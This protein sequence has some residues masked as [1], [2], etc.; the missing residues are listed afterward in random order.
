MPIITSNQY[1]EHNQMIDNAQY[2]MDF[3]YTAGWTKNAICG[4]LGNME[5]ESTMNSGLWESLDEGN[6]QGGFGLVQWTPVSDLVVWLDANGY[7]NDWTNIT[8]QLKRILAEVAEGGQWYT[9]PPYTLTFTEFTHSTET[10]E[11]LA[12]AFI[13]CYER[14]FNADQP[15]R[16][17]QAREWFNT[18]NPTT[19]QVNKV[20]EAILWM[21]AI[22][23]DNT[24]GY[25]QNSRC[26]PDYDCSSFVISG[27]EQAG[28]LLKTNG[29][30]YT[31]D[32][33]A[34][35]LSTGFTQVDWNNDVNN[36]VR[37]D[38]ILNELNHVCCYIGNGKI[39][40][41]SANEFGT[42]TGGQTGDQTE[43]EIY[44]RDYYV[45]SSGWDCVL[46]FTST[47]IDPNTSIEGDVYPKIL[48]SS[49]NVNQ[50]TATQITFLK[51]LSTLSYVQPLPPITEP[52]TV[53]PPPIRVAKM[54]FTFNHNKRQI[55]QNY[56]GK[57]LTF[58]NK[59]YKI[60]DV[61]NDGY[62]ILIYGDSLCYNYVN[63]IYIKSHI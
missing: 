2:I 44:V 18:L 47:P 63:P 50:L 54:K 61:R 10:P 51:T 46:R 34:V 33:K 6:M 48:A 14:P 9:V 39:V 24:H 8:G 3:L 59:E 56:M 43:T 12:D 53:Y 7:A 32:M 15:I 35:C 17:T 57:K 1:L 58:D 40:Q 36:L 52:P 21:I 31:G 11:Y 38:I 29:A 13:N 4:V 28:I 42:A 23:N 5:T 27:Y 26:S 16:G 55:G 60:K 45:Y 20:E 41:A 49:Y 62:I 22:A 37:G 19:P 25:D 30:T